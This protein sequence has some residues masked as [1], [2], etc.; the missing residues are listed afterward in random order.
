MSPRGSFVARTLQYSCRDFRAYLPQSHDNLHRDE[1][2]AEI[3][4]L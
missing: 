2:A 4:A 3:P 1:A